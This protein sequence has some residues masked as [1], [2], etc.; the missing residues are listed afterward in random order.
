MS[1]TKEWL[2]PVTRT[3][4]KLKAEG[5][6]YALG[7]QI[8]YFTH[9]YA[10][11]KLQGAGLLRNPSAPLIPCHENPKMVS[12]RT[13]L[14]LIGLTDFYDIDLNGQAAL[15]WDLSKPIPAELKGRAGVV[16]DIGTCEHIFN[17][18]QV[19]ANIVE[20]LGTGGLVLHLAPLS[21]YN[22][23]F[24]NFNPIWFKEFY[25]CN[26]FQLLE[27]GLIVAPFAY[28]MLSFFERL[29]LEEHF[30]ES[31]I[32]PL[33]FFLNDESRM[34]ARIANHFG[35]SGRVI[36]LFAARK[37]VDNQGVVFPCQEIYR[38]SILKP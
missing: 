31:R 10:R 20:L 37:T 13:V 4:V 25:Q 1:L 22:H 15:N 30:L 18:T 36:I 34:L 5:P 2:L 3:L 7:D 38:Q 11:R 27:H 26:Q 28:S 21:W 23:G 32:A 9:D 35:M 19:F 29:G 12:F 24:V 8:T 33:S 14:A 17:L 16:I 6:V